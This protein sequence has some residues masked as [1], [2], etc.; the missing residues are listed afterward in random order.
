[1]ILGAV[2]KSLGYE[3]RYRKWD[4][5]LFIEADIIP[6]LEYIQLLKPL[7]NNPF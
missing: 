7:E 6:F 3:L 1:M 4:L 5:E 2:I